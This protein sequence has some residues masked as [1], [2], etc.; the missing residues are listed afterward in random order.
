VAKY[1][2]ESW[3]LNKDIAKRLATFDTK[4]LRRIFWEI[5][6]NENRRTR[7]NTELMQLFGVFHKLSFVRTS[8]LNWIGHVTRVDSRR[9]VFHVFKDNPQGSQL[10]GR[11][12]TDGGIVY[13][14][15]LVNAK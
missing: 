8:R 12:K 11:P 3:T 4:V 13:K 14:Q 10:R 1:G 2:A 5:K 9:K 15:I 6:V 7:Y